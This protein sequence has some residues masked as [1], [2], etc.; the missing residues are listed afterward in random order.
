MKDSL[1]PEQE[2]VNRLVGA[3]ALLSWVEIKSE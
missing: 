2:I 3:W 1:E